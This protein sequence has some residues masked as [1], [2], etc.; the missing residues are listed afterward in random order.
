MILRISP[1][2]AKTL[3][4]LL[5][6]AL[7]VTIHTEVQ[8][9]R[10]HSMRI[11]S[12]H[13][14][15]HHDHDHQ[16]HGDTHGAQV[17]KL[18]PMR[19]RSFNQLKG[20]LA[21]KTMHNQNNFL[22]PSTEADGAVFK[23]SP[24]GSASPEHSN[25]N[26]QVNGVDEGDQVKTD[27][28]YIYSIQNAKV[29][30][31]QAFPATA[32]ALTATLEFDAS[33]SPA[34]LYVDGNQ[35]V[36]VGSGW[37]ANDNGN[38]VP[39]LEQNGQ[40]KMAIWAPSGESRTLV[41][42]YDVTDPAKPG[43]LREFAF[44]GNYLSSRKIGSDLYLIGRKY[45]NY[46]FRFFG[47]VPLAESASSTMTED[48]TLPHI[49]D[50]LV[51]D[52][53][54]HTLPVSDIYVFPNFVEPNYVIVAGIKL[55]DLNQEAD[56][57][58]YLGGG[59]TV[60][61]STRHLYISA[62][63]YNNPTNGEAVS[64]PFTNLYKFA[65]NQGSVSF[66]NA[67][68]VPGIPLNQ[69]AM[70]EYNGYFRI[71]TTVDQWTKTG[72]TGTSK[73]WNNLYTL[74]SNMAIT[75]RLEHL[76]EG[77]RIFSARFMGDRGYLVTF[78]QVDPL[79]VIDLSIP[80]APTVLGE[81]K[82]PGFSNYLHPFDDNHIIGFGQ[83]T[84]DN[85]TTV[86]ISG[87]KLALFDVTDVNHPV[88]KHSLVLGEQG[89]YSPLLYDHKAL[90]FDKTRS[91]IG[92][93]VSITAQKPGEEWPSEVFQGAHVYKVTLAH[94][95]QKQAAITHHKNGQLYDWHHYINRLLTIDNQLY[96]VS[97]GR[98]QANDMGAYA[99]T[100]LLD[101]PIEQ[102][103]SGCEPL[104]S[105]AG[106]AAVVNEVAIDCPILIDPLPK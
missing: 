42:I 32:M 19:I 73:T 39:V 40:A 90:L 75:G 65:F 22:T 56:V 23:A 82:I 94:G 81:L 31:I 98:I 26:V 58:A 97:E 28:H 84:E 29:R 95:F 77:E 6:A 38:N 80:Q 47:A 18:K 100:G 85:G 2:W 67:G 88:Q 12:G 72:D 9:K 48:N 8:A 64:A 15:S 103:P 53:A 59:E 63:D 24:T 13:H 71:A 74:N 68:E 105:E 79:F 60:Y 20:L 21:D 45:P 7:L 5:S 34:E 35:L 43:L 10:D 49:S 96:T 51:D 99:L 36:V 83:D 4:L 102:V 52:G 33:F 25:T 70:D 54:D 16:R 41:R 62:A 93:P 86:S 30:I 92:F 76:A 104:A 14:R 87:M 17:K 11:V 46:Y 66:N 27:G 69:F 3:I 78:Q 37:L 57:K 106:D 1:Y 89:S 61:A 55:D 91:L 44:T 101:L 50:S